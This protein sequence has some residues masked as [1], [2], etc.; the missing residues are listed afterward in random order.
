MPKTKKE[1]TR[2]HP[3]PVPLKESGPDSSGASPFAPVGTVQAAQ[4]VETIVVQRTV[5]EAAVLLPETLSA[6]DVGRNKKQK[7]QQRHERWLEK[8]GTVYSE[9]KGKKTKGG[10]PGKL[11]M[12]DIRDILP[13]VLAQPI[14]TS[15][16]TTT[17]P[18]KPKPVSQSARRKT[19]VSEIVRLQKVLL[20]P[21]FRNNPIATIKRHLQ[22]T[23]VDSANS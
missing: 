6:D 5:N 7:R 19:G 23:I 9:R 10:D 21:T 14:A 18:S 4:D 11:I 16:A 8:L 12:D 3:K 15:S 2:R 22:N 1:R 17:T 13:T 20:H